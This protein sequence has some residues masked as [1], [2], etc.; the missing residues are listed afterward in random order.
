M[1]GAVVESRL[2]VESTAGTG[3]AGSRSRL[4]VV[5]VSVVLSV[6]TLDVTRE[7]A[8]GSL[9]DDSGLKEEEL[10]E[11]EEEE[12]EG[13]GVE[14]TA[15]VMLTNAS[16]AETAGSTSASAEQQN[17]GHNNKTTHKQTELIHLLQFR[18]SNNTSGTH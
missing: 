8:V 11:E 3:V 10:D 6:L 13:E 17:T 7:V 16:K 5:L 1:E 12:E 2:S 15:A 18:K 9:E 14:N 4:L